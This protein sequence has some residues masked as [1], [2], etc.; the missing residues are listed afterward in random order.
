MIFGW[1]NIKFQPK[2][3]FTVLTYREIVF[4]YF[5][6]SIIPIGTNKIVAIIYVD[7]SVSYSL[8]LN[9]LLILFRSNLSHMFSVVLF[10]SFVWFA[11]YCR[12]SLVKKEKKERRK[13]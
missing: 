12:D 10:I 8:S 2:N 13:K 7:S 3:G 9:L 4:G 6:G 1:F 11:N 5:S